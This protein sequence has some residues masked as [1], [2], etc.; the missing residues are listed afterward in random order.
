MTVKQLINKLQKA[1]P[2]ALVILASDMEW[3]YLNTLSDVRIKEDG[4]FLLFQPRDEDDSDSEN[5]VL[6]S[7]DLKEISPKPKGLRKC[8]VIA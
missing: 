4:D 5:T 8:I 2:K 6:D 7:E 3:N 1:D